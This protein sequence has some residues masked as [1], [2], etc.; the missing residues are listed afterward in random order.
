M[1]QAEEPHIPA[2]YNECR[3]EG[4]TY[5]GLKNWVSTCHKWH[6]AQQMTHKKKGI[7]R[8]RED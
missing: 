4:N 2:Q 6:W 3:V 7:A 8:I 5:L 1:L